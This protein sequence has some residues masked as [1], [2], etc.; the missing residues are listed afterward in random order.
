MR[1]VVVAVRL[2]ALE[3]KEVVNLTDAECLGVIRQAQALIDTEA[4]RVE[5]LL[6][7]CA[8]FVPPWR[9][10][11]RQLAVPWRAIRRIG[12]EIVLI[13]IR[14]PMREDRRQGPAAAPANLAP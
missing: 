12:R 13:E 10:Q 5:A 14:P 9:G 1:Q 4:G 7:P 8:R 6:V 11:A 3:G 2:S